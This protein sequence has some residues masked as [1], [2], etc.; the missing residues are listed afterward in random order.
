[1]VVAAKS[2]VSSPA[3]RKPFHVPQVSTGQAYA[4]LGGS[5]ASGDTGGFPVTGPGRHLVF[6]RAL[7][8][9]ESEAP[10]LDPRTMPTADMVRAAIRPGPDKT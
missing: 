5:G 10:G 9:S 2:P 1:L 7:P 4:V 8:L 6:D 3:L